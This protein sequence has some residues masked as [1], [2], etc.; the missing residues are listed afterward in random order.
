[1]VLNFIFRKVT[2]HLCGVSSSSMER[3]MRKSLA[4][5]YENEMGSGSRSSIIREK[6]TVPGMV[7]LSFKIVV[8]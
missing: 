3:M 2:E 7:K 8:D 1:M 6:E 5:F 4:L